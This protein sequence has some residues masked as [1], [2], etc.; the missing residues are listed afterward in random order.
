MTSRVWISAEGT[1]SN[2]RMQLTKRGVLFVGA[3]SRAIVIE[4]RFAAD[5]WCSTDAT[6]RTQ[7]QGWFSS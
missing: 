2:K 6:E 4:S 7:W 3:P 1:L 5:P